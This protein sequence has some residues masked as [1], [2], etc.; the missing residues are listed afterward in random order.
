MVNVAVV[1]AS[2]YSGLEL[3]KI[4]LNH[5]ETCLSYITGT[6][7]V[8]G[9]KISDLYPVLRDVTDIKFILTDIDQII[10]SDADCVFMATP[11]ETSLEIVP[12]I[13]SNTAKKVIDLSGSFRL[14]YNIL[15]PIYYGFENDNENLL[16]EAVY[17]LPELYKQEIR[18]SRLVANPGCYP[19]SVVIPLVPLLRSNIINTQQRIIIDSKSGVSGAGRKPSDNT[20]Y[21]ETNES[22]KAYNIHKHRHEPEIAQ[23]LSKASGLDVKISFTP[24]L[25]P[26]NRGILSTIY[27]EVKPGVSYE[28]IY[29]C[30]IKLYNSEKFVRVMPEGQWPEIKHVV[31]TPYCDIGFSLRNQELIIVSCIDNLLKGASSQAVQNYNLMF[32]FKEH[33]AL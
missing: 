26:L 5:S 31:S 18:E 12:Q 23:E 11:N 28:D 10:N 19:T 2:G 30:W 17:G 24:H 33:L 3:V 8:A 29:N 27:A 6:E 13:I 7:R 20:H 1:G 4:L 9:Y 14:K 25:V 32:G 15:Y 22:L 21:V 16:Q